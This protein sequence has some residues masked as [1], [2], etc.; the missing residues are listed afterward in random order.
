MGQIGI[1]YLFFCPRGKESLLGRLKPSAGARRRQTIPS[2]IDV[3]NPILARE[4]QICPTKPKKLNYDQEYDTFF[5]MF[6]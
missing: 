2:S 6:W 4:G 1:K 3:F 5:K